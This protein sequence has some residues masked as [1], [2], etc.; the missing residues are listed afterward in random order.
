MTMIIIIIVITLTMKIMMIKIILIIVVLITLNN[1]FQLGDFP[2][3]LN[4]RR[5]KSADSKD[6]Y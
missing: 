3:L 2:P 1:P 6:Y 5:Y 4:T